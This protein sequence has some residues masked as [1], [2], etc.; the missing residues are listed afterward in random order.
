M[1]SHD[2]LLDGTLMAQAAF[3]FAY[4]ISSFVVAGNDYAGFNGVITGFIFGG[5]IGLTY[6]GLKKAISRTNYGIILGACSMLVF[7]CLES[8]IFWGQYSSCVHYSTV[9]DSSP[10]TTAPTAAPLVF[11]MSD[12]ISVESESRL[13]TSSIGSE[14]RNQKAM[15]SMCAFS[16]F[17]FLSYLF[18]LTLLIR[19]KNDFLGSAPL[20]E[21]Y[22]PVVTG[23]PDKRSNTAK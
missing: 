23:V 9:E 5:S 19:F 20:N 3:T 22:D 1:Y 15:K 12:S 11:R 21:G 8:S 10:P 4:L 17:M 7:V 13:L 6:Y 2:Q 14:C 16:V 18:L